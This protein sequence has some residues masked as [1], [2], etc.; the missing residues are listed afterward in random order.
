[1]DHEAATRIASA[2]VNIPWEESETVTNEGALILARAYLALREQ[3]EG[4]REEV[5]KGRF[6]ADPAAALRSSPPTE[7]SGKASR[8]VVQDEH[9]GWWLWRG[10]ASPDGEGVLWETE[11]VIEVFPAAPPTEVTDGGEFEDLLVS[12]DIAHTEYGVWAGSL[13]ASEEE[14]DAKYRA[15][16]TARTALIEYE[17][18][19]RAR[20]QEHLDAHS[21]TFAALMEISEIV[22]MVDV[23]DYQEV[24]EKVRATVE[25]LREDA[26][27]LDSLEAQAGDVDIEHGVG[28]WYLSGF[29]VDVPVCAPTLREAI[30]IFRKAA[31]GEAENGA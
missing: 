19:I 29:G 16:R 7:P 18:R 23:D 11:G 5:R 24:V 31:D 8:R 14:V 2:T 26:A 1:M 30:D 28:G 20:S 17:K 15:W 6:A 22:G 27:R 9:G 12:A 21:A 4:L 25:R 13:D 10:T 3:N